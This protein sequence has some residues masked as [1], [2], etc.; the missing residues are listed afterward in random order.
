MSITRMEPA[1]T[2]TTDITVC[3]YN[4]SN[5]TVDS[6]NYY[7]PNDPANAQYYEEHQHPEVPHN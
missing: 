2:R 3:F 1:W 7:D 4:N 5:I 6:G